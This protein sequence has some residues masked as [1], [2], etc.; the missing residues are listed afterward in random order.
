[1]LK[2]AASSAPACT[3][4]YFLKADQPP[5]RHPHLPFVHAEIASLA[6]FPSLSHLHLQ[7]QHSGNN[8]MAALAM[9]IDTSSCSAPASASAPPPLNS[10]PMGPPSLPALPRVTHLALTNVSIDVLGDELLSRVL[11][12][13]T[14]LELRG[15]RPTI[16]QLQGLLEDGPR[17]VGR[18]RHTPLTSL[19]L[20][21]NPSSLEDPLPLRAL[22]GLC[23][24]ARLQRLDLGGQEVTPGLLRT[25][26]HL[27][28]LSSLT[29]CRLVGEDRVREMTGV[30]ASVQGSGFWGLGA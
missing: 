9:D 12:A 19:T 20:S 22:A 2:A 28:A 21:T 24:L 15:C 17:T 1:M 29:V 25:L 5:L 18:H 13:L 4:L 27:P 6:H 11:P 16:A 7:V 8:A 10:T 30:S 26:T 14:H 23:N 3:T